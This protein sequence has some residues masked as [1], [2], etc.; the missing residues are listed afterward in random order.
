VPLSGAF[1]TLFPDCAIAECSATQLGRS[2][3]RNDS[4]VRFY[5]GT[6]SEAVS[7]ARAR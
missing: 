3:E 7:H 5:R 4:H 1:G 6:P 2:V